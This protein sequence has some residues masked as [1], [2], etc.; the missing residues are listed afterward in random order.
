[1]SK[2][3]VISTIFPITK[4]PVLYKSYYIQGL[5]EKYRVK[6]NVTG[7]QLQAIS[8]V[9][10][11]YYNKTIDPSTLTRYTYNDDR[12]PYCVIVVINYLSRGRI[13][14]LWEYFNNWA[15][16]LEFNYRNGITVDSIIITVDNAVIT[17]DKE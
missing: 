5:D 14:Y 12:T 10:E 7:N 4:Y 11:T 17:V 2:P 15:G 3:R 6:N 8:Q 16:I 9:Y 1:M 13:I